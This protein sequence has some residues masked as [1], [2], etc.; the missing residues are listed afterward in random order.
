MLIDL[1]SDTVTQPTPAMREAIAQA[2][3]AYESGGRVAL[4][5]QCWIYEAVNPV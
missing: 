3:E 2:L 5:S 4:G 1:R